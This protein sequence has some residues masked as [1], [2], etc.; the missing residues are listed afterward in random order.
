MDI[1]ASRLLLQWLFVI[2]SYFTFIHFAL[3]R[4]RNKD[5][6]VQKIG[7]S[8]RRFALYPRAL[9]MGFVVWIVAPWQ[10][11][12]RVLQLCLSNSFHKCPI[13]KCIT[14]VVDIMFVT[15]SVCDLHT[16]KRS[17]MQ[18]LVY[19][20]WRKLVVVKLVLNIALGNIYNSLYLCVY[21]IQ[22]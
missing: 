17:R 11:F 7:L 3:V 4:K 6:L 8:P 22:N 15:C 19:Y 16:S 14:D 10:V 2:S 18:D 13:Q 21:T 5:V 12:P 9:R 20:S 1:A